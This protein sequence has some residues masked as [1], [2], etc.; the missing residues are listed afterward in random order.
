MF[1][2][3]CFLSNRASQRGRFARCGGRSAGDAPY[4]G[5]MSVKGEGRRD[6]HTYSEKR[7][8]FQSLARNNRNEFH[9]AEKRHF[10]GR[11]AWQKWKRHGKD[12]IAV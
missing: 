4:G 9:F 11:E 5:N 2:R 7:N 8:A 6:G 1:A 3:R 10:G 12:P